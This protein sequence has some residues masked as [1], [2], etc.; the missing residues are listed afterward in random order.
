MDM[1]Q[2]GAAAVDITGPVGALLGGYGGRTHG[3]TG[4]H[5]PLYVR[6]LLLSDGREEI[7]IAICDL[8]GVSARL[9]EQARSII[10]A[11]CG[12]PARNVC[13]AATHTHDGPEDVIRRGER[14]YVNDTAH[15]IAGAVR[16]ARAAAR[17]VTLK[18]GTADVATVSQNR[19]DPEGPIETRAKVLLA[20]PPGQV[21]PVATLVNFACHPTVLERDNYLYTADFPGATTA[22]LERALGG[23]AIF[24]QGAAGDINPVWMRHDFDEAERIGKILGA[25]AT[26]TALELRPLG[27]G[28]WAV[29]L[30]WSEITPQEPAPGTVLSG[31]RVRGA[32]RFL[33]LPRRV[34]APQAELERE[35]ASIEVRL[36]ALTE[37]DVSGR[38]SLRPGLNQL[39]IER[40]RYRGITVEPGTTQRA[41]VQALRISDE[42]AIVCLPGEFLVEIGWELERRCGVRHLLVCGYSNDYLSYVPMAKHFPEAGYEVGCAL[43]EPECAEIMIEAAVAL[44]RSLYDE[45]QER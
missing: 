44:V 18:L 19:R 3:A 43:F 34:P 30:S 9:V 4:I 26:R 14:A 5:D 27:E 41:E 33:D 23:A 40:A 42:C 10:E 13:I 32:Q 36:A 31:P 17:P 45:E 7:V 38:R 25:A 15:K 39:R 22:F 37:E 29:N 35:I 21:T 24:M 1:W 16:I 20:A 12:I 28:Q 6:A 11:E 8:V 2:A